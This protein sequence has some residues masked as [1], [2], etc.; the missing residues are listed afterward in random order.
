MCPYLALVLYK[1]GQTSHTFTL[2]LEGRVKLHVGR[3]RL[4][5]EGGPFH[6]LATSTLTDESYIPDFDAIATTDCTLIQ[7]TRKK[8][9]AA[10]S[11]TLQRSSFMR[12]P[13]RALQ[14]TD[15]DPEPSNM[16]PVTEESGDGAVDDSASKHGVLELSEEDQTTVRTTTL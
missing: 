8:Y 12:V 9:R 1:N 5:F 4:L 7:I 3:D 15:L 14:S 16:E 11:G 2:I 13:S 6:A 10:L